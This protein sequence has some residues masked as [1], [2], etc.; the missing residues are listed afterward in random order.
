M[1]TWWPAVLLHPIMEKPQLLTALSPPDCHQSCAETL[2][3]SFKLNPES[4]VPDGP[5]NLHPFQARAEGSR[6]EALGPWLPLWDVMGRYGTNRTAG[7]L[8]RSPPGAAQSPCTG[9]KVPHGL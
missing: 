3:V 6:Y 4:V 9:A 8:S 5:S 2:A 1:A 7:K